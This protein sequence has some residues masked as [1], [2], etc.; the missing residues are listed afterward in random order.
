MSYGAQPHDGKL[1][2]ISEISLSGLF[3]SRF[4]ISWKL[5]VIQPIIANHHRC[6]AKHAALD[7]SHAA[8]LDASRTPENE[9][10]KY[11]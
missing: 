11:Y 4:L 9:H 8:L 7:L 1:S 5:P 2:R 3:T 10:W 6:Q